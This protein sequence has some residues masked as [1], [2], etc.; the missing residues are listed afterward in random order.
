MEQLITIATYWYPGDYL[1]IKS[2]LEAEGINV[3]M[4][5][6]NI[7]TQDPLVTSAVGGI[8]LQVN[9]N[10]VEKALQII[11]E[12][13]TDINEAELEKLSEKEEQEPQEQQGNTNVNN[14]T[15]FIGVAVVLI[16]IA[17]LIWVKKYL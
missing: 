17:F 6:E 10:D 5:D 7:V 3:F 15:A 4:K 13:A 14:L 12:H 9:E 1:L 8:K 16:F 2:R 11:K